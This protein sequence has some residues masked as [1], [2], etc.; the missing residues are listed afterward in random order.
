MQQVSKMKL[1]GGRFEM[2]SITITERVSA[3][4]RRNE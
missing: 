3:T 1:K 4:Q 2:T